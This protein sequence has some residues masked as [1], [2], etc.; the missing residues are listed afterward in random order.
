MRSPTDLSRAP[1]SIE[2]ES[3]ACVLEGQHGFF[4]AGIAEFL[5]HLSRDRGDTGRA[6]MWTRVAQ[7]IRDRESVRIAHR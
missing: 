6:Q 4:A 5:F 3:M 7:S 2:V 1:N